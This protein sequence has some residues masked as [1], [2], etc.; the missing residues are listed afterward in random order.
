MQSPG[1][2]LPESPVQ[3]K[4]HVAGEQP[5]W[6]GMDNNLNKSQKRQIG[7]CTASS[8]ALL[9]EIKT[10]AS[11]SVLLRPCLKYAIFSS[12]PH[13]SSKTQTDE[14]LQRRTPKIIKWLENPPYEKRLKD[15]GLW[16]MQEGKLRRKLITAFQYLKCV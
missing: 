13:S 4:K 1:M 2:T 3:T 15:L 11:Y 8:G 5:C 14:R 7:S 6:K 12:Q 16:C 10:G 9:T